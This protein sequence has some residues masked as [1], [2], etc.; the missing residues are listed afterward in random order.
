MKI[1]P[2][3]S[4]Y[5]LILILLITICATQSAR[6]GW[7]LAVQGITPLRKCIMRSEIAMYMLWKSV[8]KGDEYLNRRF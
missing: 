8:C 3:K 7:R 2:C 4:E 1:K 5:R 6:A